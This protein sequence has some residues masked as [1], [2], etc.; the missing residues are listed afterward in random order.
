[1]S[2]LGGLYREGKRALAEAGIEGAAFEASCLMEKA[3]G[4]N[5]QQRIL[6]DKEEADPGGAEEFRALVRERAGGRPL[7]YLLGRWPF[8]GMDL[9][10]GEGVL[11][12]REETELLAETA[13]R[14]LTGLPA[15]RVLDLCSGTGAVA[16]ALGRAFPRAGVSAAEW[17]PAAFGYL[18]KNCARAGAGNVRPVR[19]DVLDPASAADFQDLDC[20]VSNPP[21]VRSAELSSLQREVRREP[22]EAL[23]GGE[24]G[25]VFYRA[26]ARLWLPA[27]RPGGALCAECGE[28]QAA[29]VARI[30]SQAGLEGLRFS[31]DFNQI[32]RVVSGRRPGNGKDPA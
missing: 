31:K 27:L 1:M 23:D 14:M 21:Y 3:F 4:L 17:F 20:I 12:P 24:D 29:E 25:L 2:T 8:C 11:I 18:E 13:E 15:P 6:R 22:R 16:L 9:L 5:R 7:Q 32:D 26:I 10:V 19:L 30:F 28:G